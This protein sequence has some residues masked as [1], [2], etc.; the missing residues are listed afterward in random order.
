MVGLD[1][2]HVVV[3]PEEERGLPDQLVEHGDAD[4]VVGGDHGGDVVPGD[5]VGDTLFDLV[6][7]PGGADDQVDACV[8]GDGGVD[9]RGLGDGEVQEHI[10][11]GVLQDLCQVL[12]VGDGDPDGARADDLP[13]VLPDVDQVE[14]GGHGHALGGQDALHEH[15]AHPSAGP[16]EP[17]PCDVA[18]CHGYLR[19][20][21]MGSPIYVSDWGRMRAAPAGASL[22]PLGEEPGDALLRDG[23]AGDAADEHGDLDGLQ[24]LLLGGSVVLRDPGLGV[25]AVLAHPHADA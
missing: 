12:G 6:G 3:V 7:Q 2:L 25:D 21:M 17:H 14:G 5:G 18:V 20:M 1:D 24:D 4:G 8:G 23:P 15:L 16:Y 22:V 9:G 19:D 10:G 11:P 13:D